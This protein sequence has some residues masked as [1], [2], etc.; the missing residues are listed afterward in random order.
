MFRFHGSDSLVKEVTRLV[1]LNPESA[2][3]IPDA[4]QYLVTPHSLEAEAPEVSNHQFPRSLRKWLMLRF[5]SLSFIV[6][7][8]RPKVLP[9]R[10][11]PGDSPF[12]TLVGLYLCISYRVFT[13]LLCGKRAWDFSGWLWSFDNHDDGSEVMSYWSITKTSTKRKPSLWNLISIKNCEVEA[14]AANRQYWTHFLTCCRSQK[15][16]SI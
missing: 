9:K 3:H 4:L 2:C 11:G 1:R 15:I 13:F 8:L 16:T 6:Y 7:M 14:I 5:A 10:S 12:N